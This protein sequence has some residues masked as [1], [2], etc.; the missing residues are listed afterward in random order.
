[1]AYLAK[2]NKPDLLEI[3]DKIGI[4]IDP[5]TR[6]NILKSLS[7]DVEE[8]RTILDRI[9]TNRKEERASK[10]QHE[11]RE[12]EIKKLEAAQSNQRLNDEFRNTVELG[13]KIQ[14]TQ[15]TTKFDEKHDE[16]GLY[17]ISFERR[18]EMAQV[19]KKDWVAYLLAVLPPDL[20]N[21]LAR[22]L[23]SDANDYDFDLMVTEQLKF[24][25]PAEVRDHFLEDWLKFTTLFDFPE[26]LGDFESIKESCKRKD[27][28]KKN[29]PNF[30]SRNGNFHNSKN[31]EN[32]KE[33]RP[34]FQVKPEA[35]QDKPKEKDFDERKPLC[36]FECGSS[37]HLRP[38]CN[39]LKKT[40]KYISCVMA[41]ESFDKLMSRYTKKF[42][43]TCDSCQRVGKPRDKKKAP[44]KI[45]PVITEIFTKLNVDACGPLPESTSGNSTL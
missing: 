16:I 38:Q 2:S 25:V 33:F 20:S 30:R 39:K 11:Q 18:S 41:D 19:P 32:A 36:C 14:L 12:L 40:V 17:L 4:E 3:C 22:E 24:R 7:Y 42:I 15:I 29:F 31:R 28:P 1:M 27:V 44:L 6:T 5:S 43:K 37:N 9:L 13:P 8:I 10:E 23:P 45:V 34:K 26:K 35:L 21:M